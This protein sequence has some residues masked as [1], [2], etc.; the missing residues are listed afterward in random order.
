MDTALSSDTGKVKVASTETQI[1]TMYSSA[2]TSV[3]MQ[4]ARVIVNVASPK[5]S[6]NIRFVLDNGS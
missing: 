1:V 3:L 5:K 4:T 6:M 2:A